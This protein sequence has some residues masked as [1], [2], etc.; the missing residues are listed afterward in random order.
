MASMPPQRRPSPAVAL[1]EAAY[2]VAGRVL[3][4]TL[5][6]PRLDGGVRRHACDVLALDPN[7]S[8][9]EDDE[10][11]ALCML[12]AAAALDKFEPNETGRD[13]CEAIDLV[14]RS[15]QK[16]SGILDLKYVPSLMR[17]WQLRLA[18]L[19]AEAIAFVD[20]HQAEIARVVE[21]YMRRKRRLEE[22][23]SLEAPRE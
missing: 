19:Q 8:S 18:T 16:R 3:E 14:V 20:E 11:A 15:V 5:R 2:R 21:T 13:H 10:H 7:T 9:P 12:V 4:L 22:I 1:H 23:T 6:P 17:E